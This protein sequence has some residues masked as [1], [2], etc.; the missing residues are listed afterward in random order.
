MGRNTVFDDDQVRTL[1][2]LE[3]VGGSLSLVSVI[4]VF[5]AYG[6]FDRVRTLPNTFIVFAS[7]ANVGASIASLIAY[8]GVWFGQE[9][10][11]CQAQGFLFQ[12]MV[13]S[14]PWWSL[15]MAINVLLVFFKGASPHA[16]KQW[17]W[18]YCLI[19]YG[20]PFVIAVI[21]LLLKKDGKTVVYGSAGIWCWISD[22]WNT[23]RIYSYY[24]LIW[25][26]I[27]TSLL[28]YAGIGIYVF[29]ARNKL[30][31]LSGSGGHH[32]RGTFE[33]PALHS[34]HN[35]D[36]AVSTTEWPLSPDSGG[37]LF[38][39]TNHKDKTKSQSTP[40]T[41]LDESAVTRPE[42]LHSPMISTDLSRCLLSPRPQKEMAAP[43]RPQHP[44]RS[45]A[46][47][48]R[49]STPV[50]RVFGR[51]IVEDPVKRA[52]L[53][54]AVLFAL[55]VFVT[56]IPSSI[57]RIRGLIYPDSPYPYNVATAAVLPLQG[58]WNGVIFFVTSWK[59]LRQSARDM[60]TPGKGVVELT[61][62]PG[63]RGQ[64]VHGMWRDAEQGDGGSGLGIS[65]KP[66]DSTRRCSWDF[67]DIS[68]DTGEHGIY[69]EGKENTSNSKDRR[70]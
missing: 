23:L 65:W 1:V 50:R 42:N 6:L 4:L 57:N 27:L 63:K 16:I 54:T 7:V 28:I 64:Y 12:M 55:S 56:W 62:Q 70:L 10:S 35:R 33:H 46:L 29:K 44:P 34:S 36:S 69:V 48:K 21:C 30:R 11:L 45:T 41:P 5:I 53:R 13:Q 40:G 59:M 66:K 17:G 61:D 52:Y 18:L 32:V 49:T 15:A 20:G 39:S 38:G 26:C 37:V 14:D 60:F 47:G 67:V 24:M 51:F 31:Q 2:I 19:C 9:S 25:I 8:D 3:R 68:T 43:F 22:D 58:L